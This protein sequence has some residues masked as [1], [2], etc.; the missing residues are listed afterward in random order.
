MSLFAFWLVQRPIITTNSRVV[1]E[2]YLIAIAASALRY[3]QRVTLVTGIMAAAQHLGLS[4]LTWATH[5][6]DGL[7]VVPSLE[8]EDV[9]DLAE[10]VDLAADDFATVPEQLQSVREGRVA[11]DAHVHE[12]LDLL[13]RETRHLEALDHAESSQ[14]GV[15][16]APS[17]TFGSLHG[18][19]E[20]LG[21]VVAQS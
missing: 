15:G 6:G 19:E 14:V 7:L 13:D 11:L 2:A 1:W 16:V 10:R 9:E 8:V 18:R 17:P 3:D 4:V 21:L 5:R 12:R 20:A